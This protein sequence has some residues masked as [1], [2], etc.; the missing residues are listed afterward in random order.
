MYPEPTNCV[1]YR[2]AGATTTTNNDM[3]ITLQPTEQPRQNPESTNP[4][5]SI[6]LP[7]DDMDI[8]QVIEEL[9]RPALLGW[10]FLE[11]TVDAHLNIGN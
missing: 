7:F 1:A 9:I 3:K 8:T 11:E 10:G 4:T 2:I 5:V 6:D